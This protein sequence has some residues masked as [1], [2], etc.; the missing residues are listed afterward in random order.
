MCFRVPTRPVLRPPVTITRL[1]CSNLTK[2]M[3]L[4]VS[5]SIFTV[6]C[7]LIRGSWY[8]MV[9]P[10]WVVITGTPFLVKNCFVTRASL[11]LA[12]AGFR[13]CSTK[14]PL[15]SYI[16]RK[17][18]PAL[19]MD[20]TSM[21]PVGKF[22]SVR[23]LPST[24]MFLWKQITLASRRFRAYFRRLRSSSTRGRHS[25]SLWGPLLGLGAYAPP[26]LD[27]I[28]WWGAFSVFRCFLGPRVMADKAVS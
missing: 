4:P 24:L 18:S 7:T 15:V 19:G 14:R 5:R 20:T 16:R 13:L 23:T 26:S 25:R 22:L 28:Q 12:S 3:A 6:S 1:P 27:S 2:S 9:R 11:N 21:K 8:R 10:S 17:L